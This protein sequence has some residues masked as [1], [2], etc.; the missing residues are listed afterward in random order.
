MH[1]FNVTI[2]KGRQESEWCQF[3]GTSLRLI[4]NQNNNIKISGYEVWEQPK[5]LLL[6]EWIKKM[7]VCIK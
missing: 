3:L 2:K 7:C 6:D 1:N 4:L 5:F